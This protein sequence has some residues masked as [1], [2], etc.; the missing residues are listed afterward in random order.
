MGRARPGGKPMIWIAIMHDVHGY[1]SGLDLNLVLALD[2][3]LA[4]RHVTRAARRLGIT[5]SA[6]SHALARLRDHLGDPLL[7]RGGRGTMTATPRALELAPQLHD[8]LAE[9][10]G[11]LRGERFDPATARRTFRICTSDYVE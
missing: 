3:L 1:L 4:E 2:A 8:L 9:L 6:A 5:Q 10:A 7:V 11:V